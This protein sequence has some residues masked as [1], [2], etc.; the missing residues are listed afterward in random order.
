MT[1]LMMIMMVMKMVVS[2]STVDDGGRISIRC[3]M[4]IVLEVS[5]VMLETSGLLSSEDVLGPL[6]R[7]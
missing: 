5:L 6:L 7:T 3:M 1:M 4:D 2:L